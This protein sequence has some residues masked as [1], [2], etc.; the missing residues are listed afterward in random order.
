MNPM[1]ATVAGQVVGQQQPRGDEGKLRRFHFSDKI[2]L[3]AREFVAQMDVGWPAVRA[4][5]CTPQPRRAVGH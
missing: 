1:I 5:H 4:V 3:N 2:A